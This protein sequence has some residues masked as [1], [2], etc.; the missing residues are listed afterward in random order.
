MPAEPKK[1]AL[2]RILK[3]LEEESDADRHI[4]QSELS[5]ILFNRYGIE[6]ERK[7]ISANL[8]LLKEAGY[9]IRNDSKGSWL[10]ERTFDDGELRVLADSVISNKSI[11]KKYTDELVKKIAGLS[12][13]KFFTSTKNV[14]TPADWRKSD[15]KDIFNNIEIINEAIEE[16]KQISF[17]YMKYDV[18]KKLVHSGDYTL[19]PVQLVLTDHDY[20]LV[21]GWALYEGKTYFET[22]GFRASMIRNLVIEKE[23]DAEKKKNLISKDMEDPRA[24]LS[25]RIMLVG[26][27]YGDP[28]EFTIVCGEG[29]LND[30]IREFGKDIKIKKLPKLPTEDVLFYTGGVNLS[31]MRQI[32]ASH[33]LEITFKSTEDA[34]A[35]F[36]LQHYP[37]ICIYKPTEMNEKFR[38]YLSYVLQFNEELP[39]MIRQAEEDMKEGKAVPYDQEN[40][41]VLI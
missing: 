28:K 17:E 37:Y 14:H 26:Y 5:D 12:T 34:V 35:R 21:G 18:N 36:V 6:I 39:D 22:Q 27:F 9:D 41:F 31:I 4:K 32:M 13:K 7:A 33:P 38:D 30:V 3:I 23:L 11:S 40:Q 10:A 24:S 29:E 1:L 15:C 25:N 8:S 16:K 20:I 19:T 2:L